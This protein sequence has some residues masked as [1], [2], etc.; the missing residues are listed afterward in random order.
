MKFKARL[1]AARRNLL[2]TVLEEVK[3]EVKV[4]YQHNRFGLTPGTKRESYLELAGAFTL[5]V[6]TLLH[7]KINRSVLIGS[8]LVRIWPYRLFPWTRSSAV[9]FCFQK[10]AN[11]KQA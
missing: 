2:E 8:F 1:K 4:Q 11:S 7:G 5:K 6:L 9:Y 10:P 3:W